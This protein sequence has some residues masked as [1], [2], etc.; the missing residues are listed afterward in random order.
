L[1][2]RCVFY[3]A[4]LK[5]PVTLLPNPS[6]DI[7]HDIYDFSLFPISLGDILTW[8]VKSALRA[9]AAGRSKVHVHL[10]TDP[11]K[12]GFS[13]LQA[14]SYLVDL[15][16]VEAIPAFWAPTSKNIVPTTRTSTNITA[17]P[18]TF[19]G[20][21]ICPTAC[22]TGTACSR[23]FRARRSGSRCNFA[24]ANWIAACRSRRRGCRGTRLS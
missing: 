20:S 12:S 13:P 21:A 15:F 22:W 19:R 9:A 17:R 7:Y 2:A 24:C 23:N 1:L 5:I 8:G 10:I 16:V 11:Q 14:T 4:A 6:P 3:A 18:G